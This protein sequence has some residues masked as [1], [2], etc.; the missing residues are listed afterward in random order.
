[1]PREDATRA[2]SYQCVEQKLIYGAGL[3]LG[4]GRSFPRSSLIV[5]PIARARSPATSERIFDAGRLVA[6][7]VRAHDL[8]CR[9]VDLRDGIVEPVCDVDA[10]AV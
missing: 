6:D 4:A 7:T 1:M 8:L 9:A 10:F 2:A 5:A 3:G